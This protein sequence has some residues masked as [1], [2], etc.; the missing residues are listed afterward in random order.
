MQSICTLWGRRRDVIIVIHVVVRPISLIPAHK[1]VIERGNDLCVNVVGIIR[2]ATRVNASEILDLPEYPASAEFRAP[3]SHTIV[4]H[5]ALV[6]DGVEHRRQQVDARGFGAHE[7]LGHFFAPK[8][9][10]MR[11]RVGKRCQGG[12]GQNNRL[13]FSW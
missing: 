3:A 1:R 5:A 7:R 10:Q 2:R 6:G 11:M 4:R 12:T 13:L 8:R 9:K